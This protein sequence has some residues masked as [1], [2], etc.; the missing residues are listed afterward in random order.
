MGV[1]DEQVWQSVIVPPP[2]FVG[3]VRGITTKTTEV[4]MQELQAEGKRIREGLVENSSS[5]SESQ[6]VLESEIA[7][8]QAELW[9]RSAPGRRKTR[10]SRWRL[11][12]D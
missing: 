8:P 12:S 4:M 5:D 11:R 2:P 3:Y 1:W 9:K 7:E 6:D 10:K